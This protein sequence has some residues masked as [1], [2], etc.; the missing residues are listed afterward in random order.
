MFNLHTKFLVIFD[1]KQQYNRRLI[2]RGCSMLFCLFSFLTTQAQTH[3]QVGDILIN[4]NKRTKNHVITN[5]M[6]IDSGDFL[7]ADLLDDLLERSRKQILST[8]LF[9]EVQLLLINWTDAG[10]AD[11]MVE[12]Q[13]NWY[14]Y[15]SIIF[16]LADR[17]FNVW[18]QEQGRS[19]D[20]INY[21]VKLSH[22]NF[23]GGKDPLKLKIQYGFTRKYELD[24]IYPYLNKER[25]LGIGGTIFYADNKEMGY[26]TIGNKTQFHKAE[27]ERVLLKRFRTGLR[28]S[29]R[30]STNMHHVFRVEFHRNAVDPY[31]RDS[32][33]QNYFLNDRTSIRF[34]YAEYDI[35]Y[36]N[37]TYTTYPQ[38]GYLLFGNI[39]KEGFGIF[40]E[41][42]NFSISGGAE[43]FTPL[44]KNLI[45]ANRLKAKTNLTRQAI[46]FANNTA[47]GWRQKDVVS[48]FDLYVM[49]GTDYLIFT[50]S[51]RQKLIE[52]NMQMAQ[53]LP[54][55]LEKM[56][57]QFFIRLN[58]DFAYVNEPTYTDTNDINN[59]WFYG[60]GPA[61]DMILFNNFLFSFEYSFNDLGENGLFI[62]S[63]VAF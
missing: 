25:T 31:V 12:V 15:P 23:S 47:L 50:N 53:W 2:L 5:E 55:Q 37:R 27:D 38:A 10:Q 62:K 9:N 33:N 58:F 34:F 60:Y 29:Y 48:G 54:R 4:G 39:K 8:G 22:Y 49:D 42:N 16:E 43:H 14:I 40:N 20:R 41:F 57:I 30:P 6:H 45:L 1:L 44:R 46:S 26:V 35:Q 56:S 3:I 21:G 61:V 51:L 36:D 63:S 17:N 7:E 24:Y 13:E 11:L 52:H 18:W 59:R 19:L 32:L 28:M